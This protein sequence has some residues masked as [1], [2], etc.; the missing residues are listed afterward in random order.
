M[1]PDYCNL[2]PNKN[3]QSVCGECPQPE[4][5]KPNEAVLFVFSKMLSQW[6]FGP[7]GKKTGMKYEVLFG[8]FKLYA[9]E[10][11][12]LLFERIQICEN[13]LLT[14]INEQA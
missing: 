10:D 7:D 6:N 5:L 1:G 13:E 12:A 9:I 14:I 11:E 3:G 2:C 4:Q 8:L